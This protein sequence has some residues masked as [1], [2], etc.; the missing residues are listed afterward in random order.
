MNPNKPKYELSENSAGESYL[1]LY[2]DW[3]TLNQLP[4]Q[5]E[6]LDELNNKNIHVIKFDSSDL[7]HWDSG[8][9]V[10]LLRIISFT[11]KG[12]QAFKTYV[13]NMKQVFE[14]LTD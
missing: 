11:E 2:G 7:G 9:L 14:G 1:N 3:T 4:S 10:F 6:V 8:L 12:R 13:H 5:D